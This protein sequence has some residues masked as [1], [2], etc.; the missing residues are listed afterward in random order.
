MYTK[1][2]ADRADQVLP[3]L[4]A[5]RRTSRARSSRACSTRRFSRVEPNSPASLAALRPAAAPPRDQG[6]IAGPD[7]SVLERITWQ[8][9]RSPSAPRACDR[10]DDRSR[11]RLDLPRRDHSARRVLVVV[12]LVFLLLGLHHLERHPDLPRLGLAARQ[13]SSARRGR[14]RR[15]H[16][17]RHP[18]VHRR[19]ARRHGSSPR[20]SRPRCRSAWRSSWPRSRRAGRSTIAQPAME[21]FVGIPSVVWGWLGHHHPRAVPAREPR[22]G[23]GFTV[24]LQLVRRLARAVADDPADDHEHLATTSFARVP[25]RLRTGS[26]ALGSTRWQTI[27]HVLLPAATTGHR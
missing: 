15:D 6:R 26:L 25:L 3:R 19:H 23:L 9:R 24:G 4:H 10:R 14:R 21:V 7:R 22:A 2:E 11:E 20:S 18:A 13:T 8:Y 17:L 27:R 1:G 16:R 12:L 5:Q